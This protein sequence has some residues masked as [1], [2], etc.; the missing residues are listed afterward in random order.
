[1]HMHAVQTPREGFDYG[2]GLL[3]RTPGLFVNFP[4][5]TKCGESL[6]SRPDEGKH[7][8]GRVGLSRL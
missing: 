7:L 1:M 5:T 4:S 6:S 3:P 2:S 8:T